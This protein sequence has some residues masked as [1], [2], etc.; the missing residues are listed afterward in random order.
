MTS[1]TANPINTLTTSSSTSSA[2]QPTTF[3]G[4]LWDIYLAWPLPRKFAW[5]LGGAM[6]MLALI[7]ILAIIGL[8][9]SGVDHGVIWTGLLAVLGIIAE[10]T[11]WLAL[12]ANRQYIVEPIVNQITAL[13]HVADGD[14]QAARTVPTGRD[15]VRTLYEAGDTLVRRLRRVLFRVYYTG[16]AL[17]R[18]AEASSDSVHHVENTM[19]RIAQ[20]VRRLEQAAVEDGH[21][22]KTVAQ[23]VEDLG[24]AAEQIALA[25]GKQAQDAHH[26]NNA[27]TSLSR[28]ITSMGQAQ[29]DG[30][31]AAADTKTRIAG[32]VTAVKTAL[33]QV[34]ALP[35]AMAQANAE[36]QA[37]VQRVQELGPVVTTIQDIARQT[38]MLA[39]NAAIEA[40]RAGDAG[41][42]F[43][44][45]ADSVGALA[46]QSLAAAE[47]T[48]TTLMSVRKAIEALAQETNRTAQNALAGQ[49][50][51]S[52]AQDA[53]SAIPEALN[54]LDTA[55][56]HVAD[57]VAQATQMAAT[58]TQ[59]VTNTAAAVEE[60]A[61]S[62][63]EMTATIQGLRTT[64]HD[65]AAT[66]AGN[67][68]I[69]A[70]VPQELQA[71]GQEM[72]VSV[73]TVAVM[74]DSVHDLQNLLA[75]WRLAVPTPTY[76]SYTDGLRTLLRA[77][78]QK[79]GAALETEVEPDELQFV[80]HPVTPN[81]LR[82][83]FDPG[84]VTV[85]EPPRYT[86]GWDRRVD[87]LLGR[88]MEEAT[89]E[90]QRAFPGVMRV[91]M[92]DVNGL[93]LAEPKAFAGDLI[94]DPAHDG[95]NLVKR[96]LFQSRDLM[97]LLRFAG[98]T[99][100]MLDQAQLTRAQVM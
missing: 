83:L 56:S 57:Q 29:Q 80:Y 55:L 24:A 8:W 70:Q 67:I 58:A 89:S 96:I 13:H 38:H 5:Q 81:D 12:R 39:L 79:I 26:A 46:Q 19:T 51:L 52:A 9:Q 21:A 14:L 66:A 35:S 43:A 73:G 33:D 92:G 37:L 65:L 68:Q 16:S 31:R 100:P 34:A 82:D 49:E 45:V 20:L 86:C 71:I 44:V 4:R 91:A 74:T 62:V 75:D 54:V 59:V 36:S 60:Y 87:R 93:V 63:E 10:S 53:V 76:Q 85:F 1:D 47:T 2:S 11:G 78:S 69:T 28:T 7:E 27:M 64:T 6:I 42:G 48:G 30:E 77:W 40:A 32:A 99:D 72:D 18:Q 94:G 97:K 3:V 15:E 84:P 22:L 23:S 25:A 17:V 61:A 95:K 88:W 90:A 50:T 41:Q 98:L